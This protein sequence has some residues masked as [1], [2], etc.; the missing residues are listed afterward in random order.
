MLKGI[1]SQCKQGLLCCILVI[2]GVDENIGKGKIVVASSLNLVELQWCLHLV[3][4]LEETVVP[5]GLAGPDKKVHRHGDEEGGRN[6][7]QTCVSPLQEGFKIR[8]DAFCEVRGKHD[9][10]V[11][12]VDSRSMGEVGGKDQ[13]GKGHCLLDQI[14]DASRWG[15]CLH[16]LLLNLSQC[17]AADWPP[18][19]LSQGGCHLSAGLLYEARDFRAADSRDGRGQNR[20]LHVVFS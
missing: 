13:R 19:H 9:R 14:R 7:I 16:H 15:F 20:P 1:G 18:S 11:C 5:F 2:L 12:V 3:R 4:L 6:N 10:V 8:L 17:V